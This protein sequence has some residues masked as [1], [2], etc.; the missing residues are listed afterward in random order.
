MMTDLADSQA[1][2]RVKLLW[3]GLRAKLL[4]GV[5][6]CGPSYRGMVR[7]AGQDVATFVGLAG[8]R[9]Q[10]LRAGCVPGFGIIC[11]AGRAAG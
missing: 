7:S 4:R 6:G 10:L 5:A 3:G 11:G 9:A 8:L 2:L 1:E